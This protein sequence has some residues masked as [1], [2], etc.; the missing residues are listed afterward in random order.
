MSLAQDVCDL[1]GRRAKA[2]MVDPVVGVRVEVVTPFLQNLALLIRELALAVV[3]RS[4]AVVGACR[5]VCVLGDV[6]GSG[7][8]VRD[9]IAEED[10]MSDKRTPMVCV[11]NS[12]ILSDKVRLTSASH[13]RA[14]HC[15][16]T[17]RTIALTPARPSTA[18]PRQAPQRQCTRQQPHPVQG[19]PGKKE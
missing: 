13:T 1:E 14:R 12:P 7:V 9:E 16:T 3:M 4:R 19:A 18:W 6:G 8:A 11:L 2:V 15:P 5:C 10:G 17:R